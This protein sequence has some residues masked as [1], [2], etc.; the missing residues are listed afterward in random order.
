MDPIADDDGDPDW[1]DEEK[2]DTSYW[3]QNGIEDEL[4][5]GSIERSERFVDIEHPSPYRKGEVYRIRSKTLSPEF[6]RSYRWYWRL[7]SDDRVFQERRTCIFACV[8]LRVGAL[9]LSQGS[10]YCNGH[11]LPRP[12]SIIPSWDPRAKSHYLAESRASCW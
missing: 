7:P 1:V 12:C 4:V 8:Y 3:D 10:E 6:L 11:T 5:W 9:I 2:Y